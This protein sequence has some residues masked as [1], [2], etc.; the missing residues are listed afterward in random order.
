MLYN[1]N[2][3]EY[4]TDSIVIEIGDFMLKMNTVKKAFVLVIT[5]VD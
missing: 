5:G 2:Q 1:I 3:I 4:I